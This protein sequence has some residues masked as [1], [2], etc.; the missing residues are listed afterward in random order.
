M[1]C[2]APHDEYS[3]LLREEGIELHPIYSLQRKGK[4]PVKDLRLISELKNA[5]RKHRIDLAI[6][7]TIKPNIYGSIAAHRVGIPSIS[8]VTGLGYTFLSRGLSNRAAQLLYR[9]AFRQNQLTIFQNPD[10]RNLFIDRHLVSKDRST[11]VLGSG[12]DVDTYE[13]DVP[14]PIEPTFLFVGRLLH[15]KGIRE[16]LQGF[17]EFSTK[18]PEAKLIIVGDPDTGNPTSISEKELLPFRNK[19]SIDFVGFQSDVRP[20]IRKAGAVILP[21]YREG[22]PRTLL[23]AL[24]MGRPVITTDVPGCRE[25]VVPGQNGWLIPSHDSQALARTLKEFYLTPDGE[26]QA[27]GQNSRQLAEKKFSTKVVNNSYLKWIEWT[28]KRCADG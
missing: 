8:V 19:K 21:S 17:D 9:Y 3:T 25:I 28:L 13:M 5:Y 4:N 18:H 11:V 1:I 7:F 12:I 2:F 24:S 20:Y 23:E 16:L 15:D 14:V 27:M 26:K 6:H 10:D 22:V